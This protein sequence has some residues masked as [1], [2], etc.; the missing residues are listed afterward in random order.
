[1][2]KLVQAIGI[3][4]I[5]TISA[6]AQKPSPDLLTPTNHALVMIDHQSQMG[7]AVKNISLEE[8]RNNT[9]IV[10]GATKIFNVPTVVTTVVVIIRKF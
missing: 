7:F 3:M 9:A 2:K 6:N 1:M 8:L 5:A 4:L 10:A